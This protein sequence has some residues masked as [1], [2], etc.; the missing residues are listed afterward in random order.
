M[1]IVIESPG[2]IAHAEEDALT[3]NEFEPRDD[4]HQISSFFSHN[5]NIVT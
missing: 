1:F 4:E 3:A 2:T 5:A